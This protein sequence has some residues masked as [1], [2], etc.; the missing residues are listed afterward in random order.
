MHKVVTVKEAMMVTV[1][2][3]SMQDA[4]VATTTQMHYILTQKL[5]F[6]YREKQQTQ[7]ESNSG[8]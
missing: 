5:L 6:V 3:K 4:C 8:C 2:H 7:Q 1:M